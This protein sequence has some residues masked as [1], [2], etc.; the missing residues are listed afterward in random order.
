M[1]LGTSI[2]LRQQQ[3][4]VRFYKAYSKFLNIIYIL[5]GSLTSSLLKQK[6]RRA[7]AIRHQG[8]PQ[9]HL[10][11]GRSTYDIRRLPIV[12]SILLVFISR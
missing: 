11:I 3:G 4:Q 12:G 1:A 10:L 8:S 9:A 7:T 2:R 6:K 5:L